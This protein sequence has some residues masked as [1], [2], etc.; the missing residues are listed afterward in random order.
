MTPLSLT[1]FQRGHI[2]S[3]LSGLSVSMSAGLLPAP[4]LWLAPL[5]LVALVYG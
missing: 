2:D 4:P 5:L 3:G 1:P